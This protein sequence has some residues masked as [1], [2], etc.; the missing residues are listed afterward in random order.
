[1]AQEAR[2]RLRSFLESER[3]STSSESSF[4]IPS[5]PPFETCSNVH[6]EVNLTDDDK[7]VFI[8][9]IEVLLNGTP[10]DQVEDKQNADEC[11]QAYWRM[12]A[13]N[14]Q[15]NSLFTNG[16]SYDDFR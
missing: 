10:I 4:P 3:I 9:K 15:M 7:Y 14:G 6:D 8:R 13:F 2:R 5:A 12:F 16:I 11:M 1:M